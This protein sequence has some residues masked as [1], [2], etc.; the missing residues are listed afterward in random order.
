M[1]DCCTPINTGQNEETTIESCCVPTTAGNGVEIATSQPN[2]CPACEQKGRKVDSIT[3]KSML[4]VSLLALRD[5]AYLFCR[6][7]DCSVVYFSADGAQS[8]TKD[9]IRVPV[10]QKEPDNDA[11]PVCYCFR[12]SPAS[13]RAEFLTT[14]QSTVV[15]E[16]NSGIQ[17]GHCA[18]EVRNPQGNCC[19]GNV[20]AV[21]KQVTQV[22]YHA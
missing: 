2:K 12:H 3:L 6:T 10:H 14:G 7:S 20:R 15:E 19:L 5:V 18:C 13:I 4:D 1:S 11:V 22:N 17:A 21:V 9:Q 16:I 8:F